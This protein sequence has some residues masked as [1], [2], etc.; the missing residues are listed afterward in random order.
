MYAVGRLTSLHRHGCLS[1]VGPAVTV[2][3]LSWASCMWNVV[4]PLSFAFWSPVFFCFFGF[5]C[6]F[7]RV[8]DSLPAFFFFHLPPPT[9]HLFHSSSTLSSN[10]AVDLLSS[11]PAVVDSTGVV[12]YGAWARHGGPAPAAHLAHPAIILVDPPPVAGDLGN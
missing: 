12:F 4:L 7:C 2:L 1:P 6:F 11:G 8:V 5:F 3:V 9:S 10:I